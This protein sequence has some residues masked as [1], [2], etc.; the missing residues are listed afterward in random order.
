MPVLEPNGPLEVAAAPNGAAVVAALEAKT[1]PDVEDGAPN[2][3]VAA[4]VVAAP[5][6][7]DPKTL[8]GVVEGVPKML[9][10][11]VAAPKGLLLPPNRFEV[12]NGAAPNALVAD[13]PNP[14]VAVDPKP[15]V[16]DVVDAVVVVAPNTLVP[17]EV[18]GAP[19]KRLVP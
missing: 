1:P 17:C 9:D 11:V 15:E 16:T 10:V 18:G 2:I 19:P 7:E 8:A 6:E 13:V 3:L 12:V 4:A 14:L 5:D